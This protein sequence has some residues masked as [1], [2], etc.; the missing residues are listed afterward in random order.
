MKITYAV[1]YILLIIVMLGCTLLAKRSSKPSR[2]AVAWLESSLIIPV[3]GNLLIILTDSR[4]MT[5]LG[6]YIYFI[7]ID[8]VLI[9]LV[10][11]TNDYCTGIGNGTQKPTVMYISIGA[12][13]F[14]LLLNPFF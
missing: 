14:Q 10:S 2:H 1:I 3:I 8:L 4:F 9:A 7:G 6:H 12:D 13:I 5:M 11:F